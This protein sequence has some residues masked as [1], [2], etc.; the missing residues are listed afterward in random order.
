ME[1]VKITFLGYILISGFQIG[2][3]KITDSEVNGSKHSPNINCSQPLRHCR[4]QLCHVYETIIGYV[5][6]IVLSCSL[7]MRH[8]IHVSEFYVRL[9]VDQ[10][11]Y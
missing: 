9:F 11:R 5:Y 1:L 6:R 8:N 7:A 2:D 3:S 10:P 4:T